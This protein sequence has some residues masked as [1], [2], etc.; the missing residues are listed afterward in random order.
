ML[1]RLLLGLVPLVLAAQSSMSL[2][3]LEREAIRKGLPLALKVGQKMTL[4]VLK[5]P[6]GTCTVLF[7]ENLGDWVFDG[8]YSPKS[9]DAQPLFS[10]S[11]SG[12]Q[13]ERLWAAVWRDKAAEEAQRK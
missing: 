13:C 5:S 12:R 11:M 3:E 2:A 4:M 6:D 10:T 9:P 1:R 7:V 8:R